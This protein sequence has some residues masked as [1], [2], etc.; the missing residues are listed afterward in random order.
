MKPIIT[1]AT[2][3]I[4]LAFAAP[5]EAEA[6]TGEPLSVTYQGYGGQGFYFGR[7]GYGAQNFFFGRSGFG[8]RSHGNRSYGLGRYILPARAIVRS[9]RARDF[10]Y[11]SKPRLRRG[12]YHTRAQDAY[13]RRVRLVIDPYSGAI[14]RLRYR[15]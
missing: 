10:C 9:L 1:I 5:R 14:V 8:N 11:I 6:F 2:A 12:L 4:L 15:N 7:S 13:G 3:L